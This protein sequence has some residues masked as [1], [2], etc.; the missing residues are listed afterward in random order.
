MIIKFLNFMLRLDNNIY[1][2]HDRIV[3]RSSVLNPI[4]CFSPKS[5]PV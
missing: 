2:K 4:P 5:E 3:K 1:L